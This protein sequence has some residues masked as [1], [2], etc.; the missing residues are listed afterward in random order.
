MLLQK[1]ELLVTKGEA[2]LL[3]CKLLG[4][5]PQGFIPDDPDTPDWDESQ[6]EMPDLA[7]CAASYLTNG[8]ALRVCTHWTKVNKPVQA[9][10]PKAPAKQPVEA[11]VVKLKAPAATTAG[12]WEVPALKDQSG[13]GR[14]ATKPVLQQTKPM[15]STI[16]RAR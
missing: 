14:D 13:H 8:G 1:N 10:T 3:A 2:A 7:A 15:A 11:P 5:V 4:Q 9:L 12:S 16:K 6:G